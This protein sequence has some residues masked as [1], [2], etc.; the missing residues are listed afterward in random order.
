MHD[1]NPLL[2]PASRLGEAMEVLARQSGLSPRTGRPPA[3]PQGLGQDGDEPLSRWLTLAAGGLGLEAEPVMSPY[4]EVEWLVR[5]AGP[6]LLR[7]PGTGEPRFLAL[8]GGGR[9]VTA[10]GPDRRVRRVRPAVVC[11]VLCRDVEAPLLAE[12]DRMLDTAGVSPRRQRGARAAVLREQLGAAWITGCWR[13]RVSRGASLWRQARSGRL[14]HRLLALVGM[15]TVQYL[16]WLLAWWVIGRGALQ[17]RF[18]TGGLLAWGLLL[19][20]MIPCRLLATWWQGRL[21]VSAAGLLKQWLLYGALRLDLEET[22][23]Q[24]AG[25]LLG[26]VIESEAVES[27]ALSGGFLGLVAGIELGLA[28][29][30]L[31]TGAGGWCHT[32]L[33][34][35]W[36]GGTGLMGGWY[37][38][39]RQRWTAA[40]LEMTHDLVERMV[41]HRTRLAQEAPEHWHDGEDQAVEHYLALSRTMD[42]RAALLLALGPRGWSVLGLLGLAPA[43]VAG[44]SAPA[45]LAVGLGGT[46][47][48]YRA[49]HKLA[50]GLVH[51]TGAALAW[52][53]IA[54]LVAAA[55]HPEASGAPTS[56]L[57]LTPPVGQGENEPSLI[58][59]HDLVF[60][61]REHGA[62]VLQDC[63]LCICAGD[64]LI[65][66]GPSGGGKSTFASL[67][68]GLRLPESGLLLSRGLDLPTLGAD[69]W[70]QR[71]VAAPQFHENHVLT[72]T[73]AFNLLLGRHWPPQPADVQEAEAV[74]R[75][76]GLGDLLD[77]MPAGLWQM[78]GE[79]GW[80]LSH[81]ERSRLY[82]ARALLQHADVVILDESFGSLDP[83]NLQR[84]LHCVLAR[85]STLLVIA[86]P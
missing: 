14:P 20:T 10:L 9:R 66:A 43:F 2:W 13:L 70:R 81:G 5:S 42:R 62:A 73:F 35:G 17:G 38:R 36:V 68:T 78:V 48:A 69:G 1:L 83:E 76:L 59:A 60:R 80:Q 58:E 15:H 74:C 3:P 18:D 84:A 86:H 47:L 34:L 50:A 82:I 6:A 71:V 65:L 12:V 21:A 30:V 67:L 85:A 55:T 53:Q 37:F 24:G 4:T 23:H 8:L 57:A 72:G 44:Q 41:G 77:R 22:R 25:Q 79:T 61:Y 46:L 56:T 31:S 39:S 32:L 28:T 19:L 27:L 49:L 63:C 75:E 51:L 40:R 7:I 33:L 11:A 54:P 45:A 16:L 26:R 52:Q 29:V 64:R